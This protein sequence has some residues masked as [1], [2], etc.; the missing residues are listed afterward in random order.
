MTKSKLRREGFILVQKPESI[1]R[2][3]LKAKTEAEIMEEWCLLASSFLMHTLPRGG[4]AHS[5]LGPLPSI[6]NQGNCSQTNT[7]RQ[8]SN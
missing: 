6:I 5:R 1:S 2:Q 8:F 3:K 4:T 7:D